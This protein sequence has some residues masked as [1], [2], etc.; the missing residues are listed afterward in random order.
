MRENLFKFIF[1]I[2]VILFCNSAFSQK[3]DSVALFKQSDTVQIKYCINR[4][5][6][7]LEGQDTVKLKEALYTDVTL[8]TIVENYAEKK[9]KFVV[10]TKEELIKIVAKKRNV[11]LDERLLGIEIRIDGRLAS[12]WTPY[13]FYIN[14]QPS[15][16]GANNFQ[17]VKTDTGWKIFS[18][19]DTRHK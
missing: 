18:I 19:V 7:G 4:F 16:R 5:F 1:T 14:R 15:H 8:K 3:V 12:V 13:E 11:T 6:E 17:L 2:I 10:E 9:E